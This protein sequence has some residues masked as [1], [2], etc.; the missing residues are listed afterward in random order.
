MIAW[1]RASNF[2]VKPLAPVAPAEVSYSLIFLLGA[3]AAGVV[4]SA[5]FVFL[6]VAGVA[7][8]FGAARLC[9]ALPPAPAPSKKMKL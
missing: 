6:F 1:T 5:R 4:G 3:G 8:V 7:G 2:A 9:P